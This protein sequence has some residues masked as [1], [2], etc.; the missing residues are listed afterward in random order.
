MSIFPP[1][2]P[3]IPPEA[4]KAL[5]LMGEVPVRALLS[6][7]RVGHGQGADI[8]IGTVQ[9]TRLYVEQWLQWKAMR[10]DFWTKIGVVA[11]ILAAVFSCFQLFK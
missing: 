1:N 11:A 5:E 9:V 8:P 3:D 7:G 4:M 2:P 6:T 10:S